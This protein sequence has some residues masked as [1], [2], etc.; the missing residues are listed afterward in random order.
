MQTD[1]KA[2]YSGWAIKTHLAGQLP[3]LSLNEVRLRHDKTRALLAK[4]INP[5]SF[6][7]QIALIGKQSYGGKFGR[8][9]PC[10]REYEVYVSHFSDSGEYLLTAAEN[11]S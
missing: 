4:N 1:C 6:N 11:R 9:R 2:W 5:E 3:L 7:G 10:G 8:T